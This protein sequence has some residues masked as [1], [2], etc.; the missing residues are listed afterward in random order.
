VE[1]RGG[2]AREEHLATYRAIDIALDPFPYS[3]GLTTL[4]ALWMGVP[5]VT[6]PGDT[7]AS[8]HSLSHLAGVGL[9]ELAARTADQYL[10]L[11]AGLA[12]DLGRLA[13]LRA[14][15]RERVARSPLCDGDRLAD[16][17]LAVL[18]DAWRAFCS[19]G[20]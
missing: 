15:L 14:G 9:Q 6:L 12:E 16:E 8:R 1:L 3:G 10:A 4:D 2:S 7:F 19:R 18:R 17:L 5:V 20:L 11:A 13:D